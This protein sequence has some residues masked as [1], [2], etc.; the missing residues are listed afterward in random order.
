VTFCC[1]LVSISYDVHERIE[2]RLI[3]NIAQRLGVEIYGRQRSVPQPLLQQ[4]YHCAMI[5]LSARA[6]NTGSVT[7]KKNTLYSP[8]YIIIR[9]AGCKQQTYLSPKSKSALCVVS[10]VLYRKQQR[11]VSTKHKPA[12]L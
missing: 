11:Q 10:V 12:R 9:F 3:F 8:H 6:L 2:I 5:H 7:C 1:S 4:R